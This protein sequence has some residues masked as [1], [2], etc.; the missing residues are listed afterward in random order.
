MRVGSSVSNRGRGTSGHGRVSGCCHYCNKEGHWKNEC[1]KRKK[2]L[3]KGNSKGHLTFVGFAT[4]GIGTRDWIIDSGASRHLTAHTELVQDYIPVVSTSITI[5][6]GNEIMTVGQ[7]NISLNRD[8]GIMWLSG[9]LHVT[10]IGSNMI[11]VGSSVD[12]GFEVEFT[13]KGCVVSKGNTESVIGCNGGT[14]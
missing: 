4:R 13:R 8:S 12:K 7:G 1:F 5:R 11:S 2:D 9:V 10:D 3:Q 14:L 6:N